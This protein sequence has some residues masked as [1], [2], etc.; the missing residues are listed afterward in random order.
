LLCVSKIHLFG[1]DILTCG[2]DC[3]VREQGRFSTILTLLLT[4]TVLKLSIAPSLPR[5]RAFTLLDKQ[6][7]MVNRS[8]QG[9]LIT[10]CF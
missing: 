7:A 9:D 2:R 6:I 4:G 10:P 8:R 5:T 3:L 1:L